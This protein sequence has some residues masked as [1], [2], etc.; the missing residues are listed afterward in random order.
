MRSNTATLT[1][2]LVPR[3]IVQVK[4]E[5]VTTALP[6]TLR[7]Q[8]TRTSLHAETRASGHPGKVTQTEITMRDNKESAGT[9]CSVASDSTNT[10]LASSPP[11][12]PLADEGTECMHHPPLPLQPGSSCPRA[13]AKRHDR[14]PLTPDSES[15]A[16]FPPTQC[17]PRILAGGAPV[18]MTGTRGIG[19][20]R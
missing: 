6:V 17:A 5:P 7:H 9:C 15:Y 16:P 8:H 10:C 14:Q 11:R 2:Y 13:L 18:Q 20:L 12:G 19:S 4:A 3:V 1:L